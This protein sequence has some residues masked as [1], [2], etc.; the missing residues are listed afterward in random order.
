MGFLAGP[1]LA[2]SAARFNAPKLPAMIPACDCF[3]P[4]ALLAPGAKLRAA[5]FASGT[6]Q[7]GICVLLNG[8]TEFIE[9]YFEVIDELRSRGFSVVTFDWRGQGGSDRLLPD[10]RKAHIEDFAEYDQN[11]DTV[12]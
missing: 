6:Q 12:I 11:L 3:E 8:Q 7:R 1:S 2:R 10:R 4:Q 9:K 5:I